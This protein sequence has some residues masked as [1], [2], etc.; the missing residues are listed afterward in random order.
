M[1]L[2]RSNYFNVIREPSKQKMSQIVEKVHK[3]GGVKAKIKIVYISNIDYFDFPK[4]VTF[5]VWMAPPIS[6]IYHQENTHV[7]LYFQI[8]LQRKLQGGS[9]FCI[10]FVLV[11]FLA[12]RARII[13]PQQCIFWSR[14]I[15]SF[16]DPVFR[17][18]ITSNPRPVPH[19]VSHPKRGNLY[20][21]NNPDCGNISDIFQIYINKS[22]PYQSQILSKF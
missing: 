8:R 18:A 16:Y 22:Q 20:E 3:G 9:Q 11:N 2:T 4:F 1:N 17:C 14:C 10:Y 12:S 5:H 7:P 6:F 13:K 21:F 19:S 15:C